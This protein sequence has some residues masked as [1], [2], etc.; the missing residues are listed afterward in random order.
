M[1]C[2]KHILFVIWASSLVLGRLESTENELRTWLLDYL[3][4]DDLVISVLAQ[5]IL[6]GQ[7]VSRF[8]FSRVHVAACCLVQLGA[9]PE[10]N[11][12]C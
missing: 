8:V 7:A 3:D 6:S 10:F 1:Q 2:F 12:K 5:A 9:V 4:T 11:P